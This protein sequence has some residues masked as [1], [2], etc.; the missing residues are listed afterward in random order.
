MYII[1]YMD[2]SLADAS[3]IPDPRTLGHAT[4]DPIT[5][6]KCWPLDPLKKPDTVTSSL[7]TPDL[8]YQNLWAKGMESLM[9]KKFWRIDTNKRLEQWKKIQK[10]ISTI[11]FLKKINMFEKTNR[12]NIVWLYIT[13]VP[14]M[15]W[16]QISQQTW[17]TNTW[18]L[19]SWSLT[20]LLST[21]SVGCL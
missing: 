12:C 8:K 2:I 7:A 11:D 9:M 4:P 6:P 15:V 21:L 1:H 3:A 20:G 17:W 13:V 10:V 18:T 5:L 16:T 14:I 19:T